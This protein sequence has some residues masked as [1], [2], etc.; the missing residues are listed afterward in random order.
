MNE[1]PS[2]RTA[3]D[4]AARKKID[5]AVAA[6]NLGCVSNNTRWDELIN[7]FRQLSGWR[8]SYRSKSVSGHISE[9][10]VEW[11]YHLPL[12]FASVEWFDI[13]LWE[14]VPAQGRLL[15]PSIIDHTDE[16]SIVVKQ[17]GFE[18]EVR[19]DVLRIWGYM[20]KSYEDFPPA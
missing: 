10:D 19:G 18:F 9:W 7:Y 20:P 12:P 11:F 4:D 15:A 6:R 13:G 2:A 3:H 14:D 5:A 1:L 17:I 8:P 16:V